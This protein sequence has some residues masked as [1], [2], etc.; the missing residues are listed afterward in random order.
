MKTLKNKWLWI[1]AVIII[2]IV[3][4]IFLSKILSRQGKIEK[5]KIDTRYAEYVSAVTSGI[6]SSESTI[7]VVLIQP[8]EGD[9]ATE[10]KTLDD[11]FSFSPSIKGSARWL[12]NRTV[13]FIP[14]HRLPSGQFYETTFN[15]PLITKAAGKMGKMTFCFQV[16]YQD[17]MLQDDGIHCYPGNSSQF[18]LTGSV[19]T[20]DVSDALQIPKILKATLKGKELKVTW[21]PSDDRKEFRFRIDSIVRSDRTE[22][23][24]LECSG[25]AIDSK[26]TTS[27]KLDIPSLGQFSVIDSR[28]GFYPEQTIKIIFSDPIDDKVLL[29][30]YI[31]LDKYSLKFSQDENIV[32]AYPERFIKSDTLK[33]TIDKGLKSAKGIEL[34]ETY[35]KNIEFS[36]I[37]PTVELL[38]KGV[39][40]PSAAGINFPFRAVNLKAVDVTIIKIFENNIPQFLQINPLDGSNELKRVGRPVFR[41]KIDLVSS[42]MLDYSVW[43]TFSFDLSKLIKTDPGALYQVKISFRKSYIN[44]PCNDNK[45]ITESSLEEENDYW[46][47]EDNNEN[48][49][50]DYAENY[51]NE[52]G[53]D[54]G[55]YWENRD[56]PCHPAYYRDEHFVKRNVLASNL[57]LTAKLGKTNDLTIVV[58]DLL[59]ASPMSGVLVDIL[60]FQ[61]QVIGSGTTNGDGFMS[62][63]LLHKPFLIVA[64]KD[65][66]RGYLSLSQNNSLSTSMFDVGGE[67]VQKGLKGFIYGERG[68]WRPGDSL[69][70]TFILEDKQKTLPASHPV[71]FELLDPRGELVKKLVK[72]NNTNGFYTFQTATDENAPTGNWDINIRVGGVVFTKNIKIEVIKPNRLKVDLDFGG[73]VF[74]AGEGKAVKLSS[75][76]LHGAPARNL[77]ASVT[78]TFVKDITNFSK[79]P[80]FIFD[81]PAG[82]VS[83]E[84]RQI[85]EGRLDENGNTQFTPSFDIK[86]A[87]G[88]LK[89]LFITKVFEE[90]GDFSIAYQNIRY[91]PYDYYVGVHVPLGDVARGMLLTDQDHNVEIVT[92]DPNGKPVDK[93]GI[94]V[95]VYKLEWR[96]WWEKSDQDLAYYVNN[97][98]LRPM[99]TEI[100]N[101]YNG[102]A[103]YKFRVKYPEWGRFL[104]RIKAPNGHA[105]GKLVYVDWPGWAGSAQKDR[106]GGAIMLALNT[107][108][109]KYNVGEISKIT[110]P[111]PAGSKAL[112]S[113]ETGSQV[114]NIGW[115]EI[116]TKITEKAIIE[117]PVTAEMA[118]NAYVSISLIQPHNPANDAPIRLYGY[119]RLN[120]E[121]PQT[122]LLP[123]IKMPDVIGSEQPFAMKVKEKSGKAMTYTIAIVDE[124]LLNINRFKTP[125]PWK[126]FYAQEALGVKTWDIYDMVFGSFGGKIEQLFAIGGDNEG[127]N[128]GSLKNSE[129]FKPVVKF[130]GPFELKKGAENTHNIKL[131]KYIGAVRTMVIAANQGAYGNTEK[132]TTV[133]NSLMVLS[134]LPRVLSPGDEVSMPVSIFV[135]DK[136]IKNVNVYIEPNSL[137]IP[138]G[139]KTQTISFNMAGTKD[140]VFPLKVA[141]QTGAAHVRVTAVSGNFKTEYQLEVNVRNPNLPASEVTAE[142]VESGKSWAYDIAPLGIAGTNH[143]TLELS[144]FPPIDLSRR[145]D[146]LIQYPHGCAEQ[147]T[148]SVFPQLYLNDLTDLTEEES[149]QTEMNIKAGL[150]RLVSFQSPDGGIAYWPGDRNADDWI[151]SYAGQFM[152]EAN[153]K[154]YELPSGMQQRWLN[155]QQLKARQW[156]IQNGGYMYYDFIQ[157][158]RLFTLSLAHQPELNAMNRL[159]DKK[160]I[161]P[162]A[163]WLLAASYQLAGQ[164]EVA[165]QMVSTLNITIPTYKEDWYTYGSDTRDKAL[166]LMVYNYTK[167]F[168]KALPIAQEIANKLSGNEWFSTQTISCCL[169]GMSQFVTKSGKFSDAIK[170]D[171]QSAGGKAEVKTQKSL[172]KCSLIADKSYGFKI[173][174]GSNG[175][176]FVRIIREGIPQMGDEKDEANNITMTMVYKDMKG[177]TI[178]ISNLRQGTDFKADITITH[179]SIAKEYKNLA[180]SYVVPSGWEIINSR[181][182]D[183]NT[184]SSLYDYQDVKD[185]RVY[186]YFGLQNKQSKTFTFLFNAAYTGTFYHPGIRCEAM[187]DNSIYTTIKGL[188]VT[189]V[190]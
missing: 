175:V 119:T 82:T 117:I 63:K 161:S 132:I 103:T 163:Q 57:G 97:Q 140:I 90:G 64:K 95:N 67:E 107:D 164:E 108:K 105:T 47:N 120:V 102:K 56:N 155:Y 15:L 66:E 96:W 159:R 123:E 135:D 86:S 144:S 31:N 187:Y 113:I 70:I 118:P 9:S 152:L 106:P 171:Y 182:A 25:E 129:R 84:P 178:D 134:T 58:S 104:I 186:T 189:I 138:S 22:T 5:F 154:N 112:V 114:I 40:I 109:E 14:N 46:E 173:N 166:L 8:Y 162:Q 184:E 60:D 131:P 18:Y 34:K 42:E 185:D 149:K 179:N 116:G 98:Y 24:K 146:Y 156:N 50:W 87:P 183:V 150:Q 136:T 61:Q 93:N 54:Y 172:Y 142:T 177:N 41:Q 20:A 190:K 13:E 126:A 11:L 180:L 170:A 45:A 2:V 38:G 19:K 48:S 74:I 28:V 51:Y 68:I 71:I 137:L 89:A 167:Q 85:F 158:Y 10:A 80:D 62:I 110:I 81:D 160:D 77:N 148:S 32:L 55:N 88:F 100:L 69:Y 7:K 128:V 133:K 139:S 91:S 29:S 33:L 79:Y 44:Y 169:L 6:I 101:T 16:I 92:V 168:D 76:W 39:I 35:T 59:T 115:K 30:S 27:M 94:E 145:L 111:A 121:D 188:K 130:L 99:Q 49:Y 127:L 153:A 65:K 157:A 52:Y 72:T 176:L 23:L 83:S 1:A 125:E 4:I 181:I 151:T 143:V 124:G 12:D 53:S 73:D 36:D 147:V 75:A 141:S 3:A 122:I 78:A 37:K 21:Q 174:N 26:R 165:K 17:F 43:N